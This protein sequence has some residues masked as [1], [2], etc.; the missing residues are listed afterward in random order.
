MYPQTGSAENTDSKNQ[1]LQ[2]FIKVFADYLD[3]YDASRRIFLDE[4]EAFD[5]VGREH[6]YFSPE[7]S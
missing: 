6:R 2:L 7:N 4:H 5:A 1:K 3:D